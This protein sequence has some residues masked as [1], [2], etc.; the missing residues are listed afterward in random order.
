ML[1]MSRRSRGRPQRR[2]R[3]R[4]RPGTWAREGESVG[5]GAASVS[6]VVPTSMTVSAPSTAL[7]GTAV[8]LSATVTP[9]N[10]VGTV[11]FKDNG[12]NIGSPQSV[13]NGTATLQHTFATA[14]S[15]SITA[16]FSGAGFVNSSAAPRR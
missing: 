9:S 14:G 1:P 15:H 5:F 4:C 2:V 13:S 12:A 10:A 16:E 3:T 6:V 7:T 8:T 11:Q